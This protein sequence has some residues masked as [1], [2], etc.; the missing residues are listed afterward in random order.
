MEYS[1]PAGSG[2]ILYETV[3]YRLRLFTSIPCGDEKLLPD[4][5]LWVKISPE[6]AGDK[7]LIHSFV[8]EIHLSIFLPAQF[9]FE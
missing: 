7:R 4:Q 9:L 2:L 3:G 1:T 8:D 5:D 6:G